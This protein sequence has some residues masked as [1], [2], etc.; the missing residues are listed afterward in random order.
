ML[1][2]EHFELERTSIWSF[3]ERGKWATHNGKYRGNWS[4]YV[5]RNIIE[6]YSKENEWVLDQFA[7]SGTT[8]VEA[9][10]LNRNA[11]GVDINPEAIRLAKENIDFECETKS[12]LEI[13]TGDASELG[14]LKSNS[15]HLVCTHPPYADIIRYSEGIKGDLSLLKCKD[16]LDKFDSVA[17]TAYRVIKPGR[18]CAYMIGDIRQGGTLYPLGFYTMELFCK[19][20][21]KS[22]RLNSSHPTTSRM[23]SSA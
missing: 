16:F 2:P 18:I 8:L 23:P 4:P 13:R 11:I 14:F 20:D 10:L 5:P 17:K 15:I 9:K 12:R 19:A 22:T 6:R 1:Q 21:R 7:G 3:P